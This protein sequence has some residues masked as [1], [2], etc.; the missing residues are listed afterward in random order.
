V[1]HVDSAAAREEEGN[2]AEGP[3]AVVLARED[4]VEE[5]CEAC[6]GGR[7]LA[8]VPELDVDGRARLLP[9]GLLIRRG[10]DH[11]PAHAGRDDDLWMGARVEGSLHVDDFD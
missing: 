9:P 4:G 6:V 2:I 5:P 10:H 3:A 11:A 1:E 8:E 7:R